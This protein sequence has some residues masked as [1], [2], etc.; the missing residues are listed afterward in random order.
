MTPSPFVS[1]Q[2][3]VERVASS[4]AA[5]AWE[6]VEPRGLVVRARDGAVH[7]ERCVLGPGEFALHLDEDALDP[8][9]GGTGQGRF[10]AAPYRGALRRLPDQVAFLVDPLGGTGTVGFT[11][12]WRPGPQPPPAGAGTDAWAEYGFVRAAETVVFDGGAG[13]GCLIPFHP[14]VLEAAIWVDPSARGRGVGT[15]VAGPSSRASQGAGCGA[16]G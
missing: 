1:P 8:Q 2:G 3:Y 14:G 5:L 9:A 16:T 15:G 11:F 10:L 7:A 4:L 6:D 13:Y 12:E